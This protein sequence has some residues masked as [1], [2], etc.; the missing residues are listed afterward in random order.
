[1]KWL[2]LSTPDIDFAEPKE[3]IQIEAPTPQIVDSFR[4]FSTELK[5][6]NSFARKAGTPCSRPDIILLDLNMPRKDGREYCWKSK[7]REIEIHSVLVRLF[8]R[9]QDIANAYSL[10]A[11]ATSPS[12]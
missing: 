9:E 6:W 7:R 4:S 8:E 5:R 11:I 2:P 3:Q 10:H 12:L 1:L